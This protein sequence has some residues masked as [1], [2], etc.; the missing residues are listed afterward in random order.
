[1]MTRL[2]ALAAR[3][4][5]RTWALPDPLH[6]ALVA[7]GQAPDYPPYPEAGGWGP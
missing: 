4:L 1:M 6:A 5:G 3:L 2:R 7:D